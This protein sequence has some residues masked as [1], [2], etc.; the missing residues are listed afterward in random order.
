MCKLLAAAVLLLV[1]VVS[2]MADDAACVASPTRLCVLGM[3]SEANQA[4]SKIVSLKA[5]DPDSK[6]RFLL[7][8]N[9]WV[10]ILGTA[11]KAGDLDFAMPVAL[12][13]DEK[14]NGLNESE[15]VA[16]LKLAGRDA[17]LATLLKGED[18]PFADRIFGPALIAAGRTADFKALVASRHL[19]QYDAATMQAAGDMLAGK[20][21]EALALVD[22]LGGEARTVVGTNALSTLQNTGR[23]SVA[24]PLVR[25][26]D[27]K[28][29]DG[30]E[31]CSLV[32]QSTM[33]KTIADRCFA[34]AS[35]M[36]EEA[37]RTG[38][39]D[40]YL[41]AAQL[42][43]ALA[44]VG[45]ARHVMDILPKLQQNDNVIFMDALDHLAR[46]SHAPALVQALGPP[47]A[48]PGPDAAER[49]RYLVRMLVLAGQTGKA[50]KFVT[51]APDDPTRDEWRGV[52]ARAL[53]DMGDTAVALPLA[54]GIADPVDRADALC[55][56]AKALKS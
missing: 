35:P 14:F 3:A 10:D 12:S 36:L 29:V 48:Y 52:Q 50:A 16:A 6:R 42:V 37:V 24:G 2:G 20:V 25:Y 13:I 54:A 23:G 7:V 31:S 27:L 22:A 40:I 8:W 19:D 44:A 51:T 30:I 15:L 47:L 55:A 39:G 11:A 38:G 56:V 5:T 53:A 18:Y 45:D 34:A 28:T 4:A 9:S 21:Q 17:D 26:L 41:V 33:D 1:S 49:G 43:G 46:F 32:A